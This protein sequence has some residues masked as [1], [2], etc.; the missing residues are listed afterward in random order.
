MRSG[1]MICALPCSGFLFL[2]VN[3]L[4]SRTSISP[5]ETPTTQKSKF[6]GSIFGEKRGPVF[7]VLQGWADINTATPRKYRKIA[8][9]AKNIDAF[10][11]ARD[12]SLWSI[13]L[14]I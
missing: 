12:L 6:S 2:S 7:G 13:G 11:T 8:I 4:P 1:R 9:L 14:Y 5:T 3:S 10:D